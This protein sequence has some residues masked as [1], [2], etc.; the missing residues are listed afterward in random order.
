MFIYM[1]FEDKYLYSD[2]YLRNN[3]I[4]YWVYQYFELMH[5]LVYL[6]FN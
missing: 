6:L 5:I 4:L 3:N 2:K 1:S